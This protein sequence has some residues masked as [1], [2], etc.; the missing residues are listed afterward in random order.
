MNL[1]I[2]NLK[3]DDVLK[4]GGYDPCEH[5]YPLLKMCNHEIGKLADPDNPFRYYESDPTPPH[6]I[7][8]ERQK[9]REMVEAMPS[10]FP[11]RESDDYDA[12]YNQAKVDLL[13][14]L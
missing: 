2:K 5:G 4:E 9:V 11:D 12:G 1:S 6:P 7:A 14:N 10:S 13:K 3:P 8:T